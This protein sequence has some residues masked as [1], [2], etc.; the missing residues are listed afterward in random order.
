MV[1]RDTENFH[2]PES[3]FISRGAA[4][5][6]KHERGV[7]HGHC[8]Y[9][10]IT[11]LS[12]FCCTDTIHLCPFI[13]TCWVFYDHVNRKSDPSVSRLCHG[14]SPFFEEFLS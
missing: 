8:L 3:R 13:Y 10:E 9:P 6:N 4:E 14:L 11:I 2:C 7:M 12:L 1:M 5:G